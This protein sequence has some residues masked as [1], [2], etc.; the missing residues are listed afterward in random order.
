MAERDERMP[1]EG[2]ADMN[3]IP[4][5]ELD[6]KV[7]DMDGHDMGGDMDANDMV[8]NGVDRNDMIGKD[9]TEKDIAKKDVG[10]KTADGKSSGKKE[11]NEGLSFEQKLD[12]LEK[13]SNTLQDPSTD[14]LKAVDLYEEGM[15]LAS[16]IDK[17]LSGI[18]RRIEIVTSKPGENPTGVMTQEYGDSWADF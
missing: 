8:V 10:R 7:K 3:G 11:S 18:E 4:L 14:L 15:K 2:T 5:E 13:I 16:A 17:E 1:M 9:M 6:A 12:K